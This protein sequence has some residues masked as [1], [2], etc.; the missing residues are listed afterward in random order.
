MKTTTIVVQGQSWDVP[1][2]FGKE[3]QRQAALGTTGLVDL[4]GLIGYETTDE[5]I[6]TWS[7]RK[8][9]EASVYA[10]NVH[11]R[12]SDHPVQ[13]HPKPEWLPDAWLG[14]PQG[15]GLFSGPGPTRLQSS[16]AAKG[17]SD[18]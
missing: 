13:R 11:L 9:V 8:Q 2:G 1:R 4:L 16:S 5:D 7:L 15:D 6:E 3:Y 14:P 12:A 17:D 10:A 18:G